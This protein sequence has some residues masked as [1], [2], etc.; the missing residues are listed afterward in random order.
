VA[1]GIAA[2]RIDVITLVYADIVNIHLRRELHILEVLMLE[3]RRHSQVHDDVLKHAAVSFLA[4]GKRCSRILTCGS[5][6]TIR[7]PIFILGSGPIDA[8]VNVHVF[9]PPENHVT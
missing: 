7:G 9:W 4:S 1:L 2:D 3:I 5:S 6:E 8:A